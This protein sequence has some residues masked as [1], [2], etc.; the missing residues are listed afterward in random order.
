M[1]INNIIDI[2]L[3]KNSSFIK[4][5]DEKKFIQT[6]LILHLNISIM[7]CIDKIGQTNVSRLIAAINIHHWHSIYSPD[8][9]D[10]FLVHSYT[11][12][13]FCK[14]IS[15]IVFR[16]ARFSIYGCVQSRKEFL[17]HKRSC[18]RLKVTTVEEIAQIPL[19]IELF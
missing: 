5:N 17:T 12:S 8:L 9:F 15:S 13:F 16:N 4:I 6:V 7:N 11:F 3:Y 18:P 10:L 19:N 14:N 2:Y 1:H